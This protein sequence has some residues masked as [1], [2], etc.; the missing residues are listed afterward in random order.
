LIEPFC[1]CVIDDYGNL[2]ISLPE[3]SEK[4]VKA[5]EKVQDVP[6]DPIELSIFGHRF[7]SIAE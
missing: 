1:E 5:F 4:S 2:E 6:L 7:M 3:T